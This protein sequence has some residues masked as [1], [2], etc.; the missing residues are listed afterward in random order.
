MYYFYGFE[1]SDIMKNRFCLWFCLSLLPVH[2]YA[3][4]PRV[5]NVVPKDYQ[6]ANKN[7]C[8]DEDDLG[9]YYV[10][11]DQGLLEFDG[12]AWKLHPTAT[13]SYVRSVEAYSHDVIF[14]GGF[15]DFGRWDRD[16]SGELVYTSLI[17]AEDRDKLSDND[18]WRIYQVPGGV[19]FQSFSSLYLYDFHR[20]CEIETDLTILFLIKVGDEFWA[21]EM[22]G[23]LYRF[24]NNAFH[25][26][27][28]SRGL[29]GHTTVQVALPAGRE[30]EFVIGTGNKGL[31]KY[32]GRTFSPWN[33]NLS[34]RMIEKEL[35]CGIRTSRNTFVFGTILGGI[36]ETDLEGNVLRVIS[37]K[38]KLYNNS[39]L[40]LYEDKFG[41]V[42]VALDQGLAYLSYSDG[43]DFHH[44]SKW[45]IGS[46]YDACVWNGRLFLATNQGVF[47]L[48]SSK[49]EGEYTLRDFEFLS[50]LKGQ[51]WSFGK[52]GGRLYV[53]HN[54]GLYEVRRDMGLEQ[55]SAMGGYHLKEVRLKDRQQIFY[56]SYYRLRQQNPDGSF[57][58][59]DGFDQGVYRVEADY[60]DNLWLEHPLRG[61]YRCRLDAAGSRIVDTRLFGGSADDDLPYRLQIFKVGGRV[62]FYGKDRFYRYN[63]FADRIEPDS[64]LNSAGS[65]LKG[66]KSVFPVGEN[67]Y[68]VICNNS[69]WKLRYDGVRSAEFI[70]CGGVDSRNMPL[71]YEHVARLDSARFLLCRDDGFDIIRPGQIRRQ[72]LPAPPRI[73]S[74]KAYGGRGDHQWLD[75][76]KTGGVEIPYG[77]NS[78]QFG[79]TTGDAMPL[80]GG[81]FR[82][83]LLGVDDEWTEVRN[84]G[85]HL[86]ERLDRGNYVFEVEAGDNFGRW[87]EPVRYRF[88]IL[89]P[90]Y[91]TPWAGIGYMLASVLVFV[92]AWLL[93]MRFYRRRYLRGLRL[94]EIV[95][96]RASN[97]RLSEEVQARNAE[98]LSQSSTLVGRNEMILHL[99]EMVNDFQQ[100]YG[101][102][103]SALLC[104]KVN[105]Y[106]AAKMDSESDLAVF[107]IK[108]EQT[109]VT[110]FQVLKQRFPEL[111][112]ND[113]R[114]CACLKMNLCTKEI[115]NLM[116]LSVRAVE[117]NRYRIRKKIG[118]SPDRNLN[119]FLLDIVPDDES[120]E[121][122]DE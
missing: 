102:T 60:M 114:L 111:T 17:R 24:E 69:V 41:N 32:D 62:A 85:I 68:G 76:R 92:L 101:S 75:P 5:I 82:Y 26:I 113:L 10:G 58:E 50:G 86:F 25:R 70:P 34:R 30:G 49:L 39:V 47:Y 77:R 67:E 48:D 116:G 96:L 59:K 14:T 9:T 83:R 45:D 89:P 104:N 64:V 16:V 57:S 90:W 95:R 80:E 4:N 46:V 98:L 115:A 52:I 109:H 21:Q 22:S 11:N 110:Y 55:V 78:L 29:F 65:G 33:G 87:S 23:D 88:T 19:L 122:A 100:K 94:K 51:T 118:L 18:F 12:L 74:G 97:R 84:A 6:G 61:V 99:R 13:R 73:A 71:G 106:V 42:C 54:S 28:Q 36:Y 107:L 31:W 56:A 120:E 63:E 2:I 103:T 117:N 35:N 44:S 72:E 40:A 121:R 15:E 43:V 37:T 108:F 66:L 53:C 93:V 119:E 112:T 81:I 3:W 105:S 20:T 79:F 8:I 27:E 38:N 7:W 91:L 1:K